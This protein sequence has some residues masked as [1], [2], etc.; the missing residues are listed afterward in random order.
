MTVL[1]HA[2]RYAANQ[3]RIIPIRPGG[4]SPGIKNWTTLA[5]SNP[6]IIRNWYEGPYKDW[7]VGIV[8]GRAGDR[9]FFVLDV[10]EHDP[11]QSGSETLRDLEQ[12]Y[13]PL[14]DT[15]TVLTPTGGKH[16]YF[17]C[18]TPIYNE[19][20][21]RLGPGLDIRGDGG[22]VLAPPTIHPNG[23]PY[24]YEHD[25]APGEIK[26]AEAPT[27]L[28][29]RL[30]SQPKKDATRIQPD[31][32]FLTD[33]NSPS[34]RYNNTTNWQTILTQDG[35]TYVYQGTDGTE[36]WRRPGKTEG[37]S[38][39]VNHNGN[40]ALIVFTTNAPIPEG[41]YS[42]FG[43]Y[44]EK[45]HNGSW[46]QA[47]DTYTKTSPTPT[48]QTPDELL[49]QLVNWTD[50]WN[51]DHKHED[52]LAYPLIP[53]G[54][55]VALFAVAKMGKSF[56]TLA[57]V[58]ALASGRSILGQPAQ[59]PTNVLYL[60]YEMTQADLYERLESLSY[61]P[62]TDLSHLHYALIPSLPPLNTYEGAAAVMKLVELTAAQLVVI[63]TTGRAV[64]G[65]ENSAD[66]YR[67][68]AR[69]TGLALK[70]KGVALLRTDHAGKDQ[71]KTHG[72]RGSSA[73]NDDVD[74]VYRMSREDTNITLDRV[75]TR[76][77]WAP[78]T[79]NIVEDPDDDE[80]V[81]RLKH[82]TL[83]FTDEEYAL[84]QLFVERIPGLRAGT[85]PPGRPTLRKLMKEHGIKA[86]NN[87]VSKALRAI[88][89]GR[90]R[91]PMQP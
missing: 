33:P 24:T 48:K 62:D 31:D 69:T 32:V 65:E 87:T 64:E 78:A 83:S 37:I 71:G 18:T 16:L 89:H 14:P 67:E 25:H 2:L 34:A 12:E 46:K 21:K 42:R 6:D 38:A 3:I 77:G 49:S 7:G 56:L 8:T 10:D 5:T 27:W 81:L 57:V 72:Q 85:K 20:G 82:D 90:L 84:A 23:K 52:W 79:I 36:Y 88:E 19:A 26:L 40:D 86:R 28:I 80:A 63:D 75:F 53:R 44:A 22:Q 9:Q 61:T 70:A 17:S 59:H 55:Q 29:H 66:T 74:I 45:H 73:K 58:A 91:D 43:Y 35:W 4:K 76:I 54:R 41:G 13:E 60:D 15:I 39:S 51:S 47:A 68:F 30:T 50:F 1:E 11:Q